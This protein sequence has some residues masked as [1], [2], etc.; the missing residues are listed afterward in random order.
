MRH[1]TT[2]ERQRQKILIQ[3]GRPWEKSTG[4]V[5]T[6]GKLKVSKNAIKDGRSLEIREI[7]K[8]FNQIL[9]KQKRLIY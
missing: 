7:I 8:L 6:E 3:K 9:R 5:T 2:E 4:P 1:W